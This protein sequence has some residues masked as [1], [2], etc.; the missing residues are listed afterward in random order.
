MKG[1]SRTCKKETWEVDGIEGEGGVK[2][3]E[4]ENDNNE[5]YIPIVYRYGNT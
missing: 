5:A 4:S 3:K 2:G 1:S